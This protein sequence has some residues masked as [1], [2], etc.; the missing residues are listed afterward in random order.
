MKDSDYVRRGIRTVH[1]K[2]ETHMR[3]KLALA[4]MQVERKE[5]MT[6]DEFVNS[7]L[8]LYESKEQPAPEPVKEFA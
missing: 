5:F 7:L 2:S 4:S 8:D 1:L 3:F 6:Q